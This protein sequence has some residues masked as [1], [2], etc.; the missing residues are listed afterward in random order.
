MEVLKLLFYII[1]FVVKLCSFTK[2]M[3]KSVSCKEKLTVL[4]NSLKLYVLFTALL[5]EPKIL[6][7]SN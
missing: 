7:A 3:W 4:N 2:H 5:F 1:F 6:V